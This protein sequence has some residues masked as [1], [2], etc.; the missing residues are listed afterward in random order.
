M[1]SINICCKE[2]RKLIKLS[3]N[4]RKYFNILNKRMI[5][6]IKILIENKEEER[7]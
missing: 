2:V 7:L 1:C 3:N 6:H 5:L 4:T